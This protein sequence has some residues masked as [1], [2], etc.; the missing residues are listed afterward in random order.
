[1]IQKSKKNFQRDK[2]DF[3][4]KNCTKNASTRVGIEL[5]TASGH[6][7]CLTEGLKVK[8]Q[9]TD[10]LEYIHKFT[11]ITNSLQM[12]L[13]TEFWHANRPLCRFPFFQSQ[14]CE[15]LLSSKFSKY[16]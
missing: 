2:F 12:P 9:L 5:R 13:C 3:F 16:S 10:P 15:T 6:Y 11:P 7:A 1:M 8:G 4:K 14:K